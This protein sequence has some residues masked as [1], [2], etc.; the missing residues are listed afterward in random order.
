MHRKRA[1]ARGWV[2]LG[3][4][5]GLDH[6]GGWRSGGYRWGTSGRMRPLER[7]V[8]KDVSGLCRKDLKEY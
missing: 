5:R 3:M 1:L 8:R 6:A 2:R 4:L 7:G